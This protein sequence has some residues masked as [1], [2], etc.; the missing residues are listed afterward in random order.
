MSRPTI[1]RVV[2]IKRN[3]DLVYVILS[4][5]K[6]AFR[7]KADLT[8]EQIDTHWAERAAEGGSQIEDPVLK[9]KAV[10]AAEYKPVHGGY[11]E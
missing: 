2:E 7:S 4:N 11:P 1:A 8:Q 3:I 6:F 9:N 5:G 10:T